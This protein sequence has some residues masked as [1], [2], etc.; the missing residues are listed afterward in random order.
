MFNLG[1]VTW[2]QS[3]RQIQCYSHFTPKSPK[4]FQRNLLRNQLKLSFSP[5]KKESGRW[6]GCNFYEKITFWKKTGA[7]TPPP[8]SPALK[9]HHYCEQPS[10]PP[11][12]PVK[13]KNGMLL[14]EYPNLLTSVHIQS[15]IS[16]HI[17]P[18]LSISIQSMI[19]IFQPLQTDFIS[20]CIEN[21]H[22]ASIDPRITCPQPNSCPHTAQQSRWCEQHTMLPQASFRT[23]FGKNL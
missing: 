17:Y 18:I 2:V 7:Q 15:M 4:I 10:R 14:G 22:V 5:K 23:V 16:I 13:Q 11:H 8:I 19:H 9:Q 12:D 20:C 1:R 6:W 3:T 21:R